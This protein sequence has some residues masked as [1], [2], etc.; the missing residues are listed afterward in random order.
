[1]IGHFGLTSREVI[2]TYPQNTGGGAY[3]GFG[4]GMAT[5]TYKTP[6][7]PSLWCTHMVEAVDIPALYSLE[8]TELIGVNGF[9]AAQGLAE[10]IERF[11]EHGSFKWLF[12]LPLVKKFEVNPKLDTTVA[13]KQGKKTFVDE[14]G[15]FLFVA[16]RICSLAKGL[17]DAE[18]ATS[19]LSEISLSE[20]APSGGA[21]GRVETPSMVKDHDVVDVDA[22]AASTTTPETIPASEIKSTAMVLFDEDYSDP[23]SGVAGMFDR[24]ESERAKLSRAWFAMCIRH[25]PSLVDLKELIIT[26]MNRSASH[27]LKPICAKVSSLGSLDDEDFE[28]L[29]ALLDSMVD[30]Q[31][32]EILT[33]VLQV[34]SLL[35]S[36]TKL[37]MFANLCM[38]KF[39]FQ[40][41]QKPPAKS[42]P[43]ADLILVTEAEFISGKWFQLSTAMK[44]WFRSRHSVEPARAGT[45]D[46]DDDD[47]SWWSAWGQKKKKSVKKV[48]VDQVAVS[49][50]A[51][52]TA[53]DDL[54]ILLSS[55]IFL[56]NYQGLLFE[57]R[58]C[59]F[60]NGP[61]E[62]VF[63]VL[64]KV[65][66]F[67][68]TIIQ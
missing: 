5:T 40:D 4:Y 1:M 33:A 14:E 23:I 44:D 49:R 15:S 9:K 45:D 63:E 27:I 7:R 56:K 61:S 37:I 16:S 65:Y 48:V 35:C 54:S 11:A 46:D 38:G 20:K 28:T 29:S 57:F 50:D 19:A 64:L 39:D 52:S 21:S 43:S 3:G 17:C 8:W 68:C 25:S 62:R 32:P 58:R 13:K 18:A 59:W 67:L 6:P 41:Q 31:S 55:Q 34:P 2:Y 36:T 12:I 42:E 60:L 66:I 51:L 22:S 24:A 10:A 30:L 47:N 53:L 26:F